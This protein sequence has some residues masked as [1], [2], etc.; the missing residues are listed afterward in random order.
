MS[1]ALALLLGVATVG[2]VRENLKLGNLSGSLGPDELGENRS[3]PAALMQEHAGGNQ[4]V[5]G[6]PM[7]KWVLTGTHVSLGSF[8]LLGVGTFTMLSPALAGAL[9][10]IPKLWLEWAKRDMAADWAC[11]STC[12]M[13]YNNMMQYDSYV[14]AKTPGKADACLKYG[15]GGVCTDM[16]NIDRCMNACKCP[17]VKMDSMKCKAKNL[18]NSDDYRILANI[19]Q[20][21]CFNDPDCQYECFKAKKVDT[22]LLTCEPEPGHSCPSWYSPPAIP[23][24]LLGTCGSAVTGA[25]EREGGSWL[26]S[27]TSC[28]CPRG[29]EMT[30]PSPKCQGAGRRFSPDSMRGMGCTC[31]PVAN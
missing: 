3:L 29:T 4:T 8:A 23:E 5:P 20:C 25:T 2:A 12:P 11:A 13:N 30:G 7:Y 18:W 15:G 19:A 10:L 17:G 27:S 16:T 21:A 22:A 31:T 26:F 6:A 14:R 24:G 9:G 1:K 28:K